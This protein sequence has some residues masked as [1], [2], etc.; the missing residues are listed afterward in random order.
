LDNSTGY[1]VST[2]ADFDY[3]ALLK[4]FKKPLDLRKIDWNEYPVFGM[5]FTET[6]SND[7]EEIES[8]LKS[9]LKEFVTLK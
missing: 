4:G 6:H 2:I 3:D 7:F 8:I 9:N 5:I 1:P